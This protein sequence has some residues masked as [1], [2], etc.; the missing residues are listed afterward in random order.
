MKAYSFGHMSGVQGATERLWRVVVLM[1]IVH[2][3]ITVPICIYT[4]L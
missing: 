4:D 3:C 2:I 1:F